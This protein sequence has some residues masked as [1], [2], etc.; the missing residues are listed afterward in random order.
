M[1]FAVCWF[2]LFLPGRC[3]AQYLLVSPSSAVV[4]PGQT[5]QLTATIGGV[6][7]PASITNFSWRVSGMLTGSVDQTGLYTA[8][9]LIPQVP[10]TVLVS[11]NVAAPGVSVPLLVSAYST[12]TVQG[13]SS[14]QPVQ[15]PKGDTGP[16]G[17]K[18]EKG[19]KGDTGPQGAAGESANASGAVLIAFSA[20]TI[21]GPFTR[22]PDGSWV[23]QNAALPINTWGGVPF[24]GS[25]IAVFHNGSLATPEGAFQIVI[26]GTGQGPY[27]IQVLPVCSPA[28]C[29]LWSA[30]DDV[31]AMWVGSLIT[32]R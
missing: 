9:L 26:S 12:I 27:A 13:S 7:G 17:P 24:N 15:G 25:A 14:S 28:P 16:P 29:S 18:G 1:K 21:S 32:T 11:A 31:R 5:L 30:G 6:S 8:P 2:L 20:L 23:L 3:V 19:D 10:V 22:R 4:A